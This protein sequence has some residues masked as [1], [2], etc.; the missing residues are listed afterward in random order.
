MTYAIPTR[1]P[2][3]RAVVPALRGITDTV[4]SADHLFGL[5]QFKVGTG[6]YAQEYVGEWDYVLRPMWARAYRTWQARH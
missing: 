6:G 4:D 2:S 3:T 1:A 5:V